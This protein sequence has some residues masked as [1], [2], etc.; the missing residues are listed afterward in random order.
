MF[1]K[2][3]MNCEHLPENVLNISMWRVIRKMQMDKLQK[4]QFGQRKIAWTEN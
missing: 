1:S 3:H 2:G 4:A